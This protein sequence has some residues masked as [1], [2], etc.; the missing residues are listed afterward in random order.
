MN[1]NVSNVNIK[2]EYH[3]LNSRISVSIAILG[4]GLS[5]ASLF[6]KPIII[7]IIFLLVGLCWLILG[8]LSSLLQYFTHYELT[9]DELVFTR[10]KKEKRLVITSISKVLVYSTEFVIVDQNNQKF[11]KI[12]RGIRNADKILQY[13]SEINKEIIIKQI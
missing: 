11:C 3:I 6:M 12:D 7:T 13:L 1:E 2:A 4:F 10:F 8:I 5:V 9:N